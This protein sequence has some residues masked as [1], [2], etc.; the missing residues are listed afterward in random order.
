MDEKELSEIEYRIHRFGEIKYGKAQSNT[1]ET[2]LVD[3]QKLLAEVKRLR[4]E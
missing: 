2:L 1:Q 3:S 4:N